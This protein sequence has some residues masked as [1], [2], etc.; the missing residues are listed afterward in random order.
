MELVAGRKLEK[1]V[2]HHLDAI[3][4]AEERVDLLDV[5]LFAFRD[6]ILPLLL[7]QLDV[8]AE[9]AQGISNL[10]GEAGRY[11]GHKCRLLLF[12][13]V[14]DRIQPSPGRLDLLSYPADLEY[15]HRSHTR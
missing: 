14:L 10:V 12:S 15:H 9:R 2:D 7:E 5:L 3:G 6:R 8:H 13:L 4:F 1:G 11:R